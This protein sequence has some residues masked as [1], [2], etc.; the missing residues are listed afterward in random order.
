MRGRELSANA[1]SRC[2][3]L[4][5]F[6]PLHGSE[7]VPKVQLLTRGVGVVEKVMRAM[8]FQGPGLPL[9]EADLPQPAPGPRQVLIQVQ[10]CAVCRTDLHI[11]D[12]DLSQPKLPLVLGHEIVGEVVE[13]GAAVE[14]FQRGDQ[15]GVPWLGGACGSCHYC[16]A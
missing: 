3:T 15:I 14:R 8:L 13:T 5:C 9:L 11:V 12:G 2:L 6:L 7:L 16:R 1:S 4:A 10:A